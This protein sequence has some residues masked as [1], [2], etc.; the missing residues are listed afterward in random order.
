MALRKRRVQAVE[1]IEP[2]RQ[3]G[4]DMTAAQVATELGFAAV[5]RV[6]QLAEDGPEKDGLAAY[7]NP[8]SG[9]QR[10]YGRGH[11]RIPVFFYRDDVLKWKEQHP[12]YVKQLEAKQKLIKYTPEQQAIVLQEAEKLKAE[13]GTIVRDHLLKRLAYVPG[14]YDKR[15]RT[16]TPRTEEG[17]G[18]RLWNTRTYPVMKKILDDAGVPISRN[19]MKRRVFSIKRTA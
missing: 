4:P 3:G 5:E 7:I 9:W 2:I 8:G 12:F 19:T 18:P 10:K 16:G 15:K 13:E 14:T 11:Q 17:Y 1:W 6:H